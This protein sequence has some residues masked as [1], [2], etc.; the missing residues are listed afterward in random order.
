LTKQQRFWKPLRVVR[1]RVAGKNRNKQKPAVTAVVGE[2][3][4]EMIWMVVTE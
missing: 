3:A 1:L 4:E 2:F